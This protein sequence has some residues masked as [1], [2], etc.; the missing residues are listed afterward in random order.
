MPYTI[1]DDI[2]NIDLS[3]H[4]LIEASAG[5]GKTFTLENLVVR[6]LKERPD[7]QIENILV[8]TFTEKAT[9]ELKAR[10]QEKLVEQIQMADDKETDGAFVQK[11]SD[12]LDAFDRAAI[13]TIHGFC[14]SILKDFTFEN[15]GLFQNEVVD[16]GPIFE[17]L[18]KEQMRKTWPQTY[19]EHLKELL[20][21]SAFSSQKDQFLARVI[22][23]VKQLQTDAARVKR[24]NG[25]ISYDDM[26]SQV[27]SAL[28]SDHC[29]GLIQTLRAKYKIAFVDEFQD[30][31]PVQWQI[32][33]RLFLDDSTGPSENLLILIGDPKQ[34]IY[35][36]RGADVYA[37]LEARNE[38]ERLSETGG[39]NLYSLATNWRSK[40]ELVAAFNDLFGRDEW[41]PTQEQAGSFEIG[42][43]G[44]GSPAETDLPAVL[45]ADGSRRPALNVVDLR[46]P[47]LPRQAKPILAGFIAREV[48]YLVDRGAIEIQSKN[49][50]P[51]PLDFGDICILVRGK[52]DAFFLEP[53][54]T[55]LGIPYSF[56]KKPGLFLSDE[57]LYLSLVCHAIFDPGSIPDVKKA[58][59]TPFFAYEPIRFV[60]I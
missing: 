42:Y 56:Y 17:S 6:L 14:H 39:A 22:N 40:P 12:T 50:P 8:V 25:W 11:I 13:A 53:E 28:H 21:I 58:L 33:K 45:A 26:L 51:R 3:R 36:F 49:G 10:I 38:M 29:S 16:D 60:R 37:Y 59:L 15:Q 43:Q 35:S 23:P 20:K 5:T 46:G 1:V 30:T 54:L 31:D 55:D 57:A 27:A 52:A 47:A 19:G 4:A 34:A 41:F 48:R 44:A 2:A 24:Q 32:F 7:I 18:L 9:S